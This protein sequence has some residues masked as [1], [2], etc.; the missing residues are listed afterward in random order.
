MRRMRRLSRE[1]LAQRI[2]T[3]LSTVRRMEDDNPGTALHTF[4]A[5]CTYL[6]A[7]MRCSR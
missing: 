5:P 3:S 7:L 2:A 1:D 6:G 4:C